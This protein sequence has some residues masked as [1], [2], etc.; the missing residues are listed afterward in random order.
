MAP[1]PSPAARRPLRPE[2]LE[3][4][5]AALDQLARSLLLARLRD[6][7]STPRALVRPDVTPAPLAGEAAD[8]VASGER[9]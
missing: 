5:D 9:V 4:V 1:D 2:D 6:A 8:R 3:L 7:Q